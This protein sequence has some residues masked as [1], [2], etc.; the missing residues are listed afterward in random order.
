MSQIVIKSTEKVFEGTLQVATH[1][2]TACKCT[3]TFSIF[4]PPQAKTTAVPVLYWLSGLTCNEQNFITKAGAFQ[5]ATSKGVAIVCCDTSPRG[6]D[7]AGQSD[8]WDF[9]VGAG[10]YINATEAKW[11]EHYNMESYVTKEL[12]E[13]IESNFS[14]SKE[15]RAIFGHSMGGHGALTL[16]LKYPGLYQSVSAFAPI[17]HPT[18][19]P[20]GQKAFSGYLG[21]DKEMWKAHD[22]TELM[23]NFKGT[24]N[25]EIL[26]DQGTADTFLPS[27]LFPDHFEAACK[28]VNFPVKLRMQEGYSHSYYFISTFISD[29]IAHH[30]ETLSK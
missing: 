4:L 27:Q 5:S 30:A 24:A 22:A 1:E 16:F 20:W 10:F 23:N 26:I 8:S 3:M 19:C 9:G 25:C 29:H 13:V 6:V 7:I 12:I 28:K 2:S 15:K 11:K 14:V 18:V 21:E 17:C